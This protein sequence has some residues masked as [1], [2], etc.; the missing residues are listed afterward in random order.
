MRR[1]L[2][3]LLGI[4]LLT[5]TS[6]SMAVVRL[7]FDGCRAVRSSCCPH[8]KHAMPAGESCAQCCLVGCV[9]LPSAV[10]AVA[11]PAVREWS[12]ASGHELGEVRTEPPLLPPPRA[13]MV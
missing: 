8:S 6:G 7:N 5:M 10:T 13:A 1:V 11:A 2:T 12:W 4:A 3:I 9:M